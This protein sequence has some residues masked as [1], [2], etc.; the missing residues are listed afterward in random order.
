MIAT[1]AIDHNQKFGVALWEPRKYSSIPPFCFAHFSASPPY[2]VLH[3]VI[4]HFLADSPAR[5]E[6]NLEIPCRRT[7]QYK[8][9]L[10]EH[11]QRV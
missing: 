5:H 2:I 3:G 7:I 11:S 9:P 1:L 6:K 8:N 4:H 10:E